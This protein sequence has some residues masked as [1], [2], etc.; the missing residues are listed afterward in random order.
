MKLNHSFFLNTALT[1][2]LLTSAALSAN[3]KEVNSYSAE[4]EKFLEK[5]KVSQVDNTNLHLERLGEDGH[6]S[7]SKVEAKVHNSNSHGEVTASLA[8]DSA[9]KYHLSGSL[10][11]GLSSKYAIEREFA[12]AILIFIVGLGY[13]YKTLNHA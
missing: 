11:K 5:S 8:A 4:Q 13:F 2:T 10:E 9:E 7:I 6:S 1:I 12:F 3:G